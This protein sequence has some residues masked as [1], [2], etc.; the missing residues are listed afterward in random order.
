MFVPMYV[1]TVPN[2]NSRPARTLRGVGFPEVWVEVP[3][4]YTAGRPAGRKPGLVIHL[5]TGGRY[6]AAPESRAFM[7]W[8]AEEIHTAMNEAELSAASSDALTRVG[9]ALGA[10]E[11]ARPDHMPWL[12][13]QRREARA[14]TMTVV[15]NRILASR[16]CRGSRFPSMP[17]SWAARRTTKKSSM[18]CSSA[19][20]SPTSAPG[21]R[22]SAGWPAYLPDPRA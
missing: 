22:P 2:R 18:P 15:A 12:R 10:R 21:S 13:A 5:L 8:T 6:H 20:T 7:G 3:D 9:R 19:R 14:E 4:R 16:G 17:T 11:G 1:E